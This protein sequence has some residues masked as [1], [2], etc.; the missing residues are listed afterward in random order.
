[1][2]PSDP[3]ARL[4]Y[5]QLQKAIARM[6]QLSFR[7]NAETGYCVFFD[8]AGHVNS[9]NLQLAKNKEDY[10]ANLLEE[11]VDCVYDPEDGGDETLFYTRALDKTEYLCTRLEKYLNEFSGGGRP[12]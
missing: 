7:V 8:I 9:Y 5:E 2:M 4:I 3:Q 11:Y 12:V 1:M 10:N 6:A